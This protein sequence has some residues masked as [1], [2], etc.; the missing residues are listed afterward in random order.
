MKNMFIFGLEFGISKAENM[1]SLQ[2]NV[3]WTTRQTGHAAIER[4][5]GE[6]VKKPAHPKMLFL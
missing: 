4:G 6:L 2:R 1:V 5:S 3:T